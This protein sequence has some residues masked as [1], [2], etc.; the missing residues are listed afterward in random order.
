[1]MGAPAGSKGF[2]GPYSK[3]DGFMGYNEV[4]AMK[5]IGFLKKQMCPNQSYNL[6]KTPCMR[7]SRHL[8]FP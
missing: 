8:F 4:C 1:M 2:P 7:I 6:Q 3:E 5:S